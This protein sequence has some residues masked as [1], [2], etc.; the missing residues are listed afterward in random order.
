[1][2]DRDMRDFDFTDAAWESLYDAVDNTQ[3]LGKDAQLIYSSLKRR[4]GIRF[5][6]DY[7]KK[8]IYL[9]AGLTEPFLDVPLKEYQLIIR[10]AFSDNHTHPVLYTDYC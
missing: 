1:M 7:H 9:K 4:L 2:D 6:G 3:V 5:F 8:Y 10:S